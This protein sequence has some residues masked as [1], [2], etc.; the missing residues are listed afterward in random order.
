MLEG[1]TRPAFSVFRKFS[2]C[3]ASCRRAQVGLRGFNCGAPAAEE[4]QSPNLSTNDFGATA[5]FQSA[6][7]QSF[8]IGTKTPEPGAVNQGQRVLSKMLRPH[9]SVPPQAVRRWVESA[10]LPAHLYTK[11]FGCFGAASH[12]LHACG[13]RIL[14]EPCGRGQGCDSTCRHRHPTRAS[15]V[16]GHSRSAV[17]LI[18]LGSRAGELVAEPKHHTDL[19]EGAVAH[20]P[21]PCKSLLVGFGD[22][23]AVFGDQHFCL[24]LGAT[25]I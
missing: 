13:Q 1:A 23:Q 21:L 2:C 7:F 16:S 18:A 10:S 24:G 4:L 17:C 9:P 14:V 3:N 11:S 6:M 25:C 22:S 15:R 5:M 20:Q 19:L 8:G 12:H